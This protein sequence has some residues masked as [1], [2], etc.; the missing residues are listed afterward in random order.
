MTT[1]V[2]GWE[3]TKIGRVAVH[4]VGRGEF[5]C[6]TWRAIV[7]MIEMLVGCS[8]CG[9]ISSNPARTIETVALLITLFSALSTDER[10]CIGNATTERTALSGAG[11]ERFCPLACRR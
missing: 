10:S 2:V 5:G 1:R 4:R 3:R 8:S 6:R 7:L 9:G 11:E